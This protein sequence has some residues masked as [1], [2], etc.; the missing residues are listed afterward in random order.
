MVSF[1][2]R[3][4]IVYMLYTYQNNIKYKYKDKF[5]TSSS[6]SSLSLKCFGKIL[7]SC[8]VK[9]MLGKDLLG[10]ESILK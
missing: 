4:V 8:I 3:K 7:N 2:G 5:P 1:L 10:L 9:N 6:W